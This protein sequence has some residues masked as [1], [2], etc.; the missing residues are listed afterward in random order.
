MIHAD[1]AASTARRRGRGDDGSVLTMTLVAPVLL[2]ILLIVIQLALTFHARQV[3]AAAASDGLRAA[4]A[5]GA[6]TS[7]G[8][9]AATRFA[10]DDTTMILQTVTV[11]STG[12]RVRVEVHGRVSSAF[13]LAGDTD[14]VGVAEGPVERFRPPG[15]R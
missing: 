2:A 12:D 4:Q 10:N 3:A 14:V 13:P 11:S 8:R 15:Q 1:R 7:D 9:D 5:N 6:T